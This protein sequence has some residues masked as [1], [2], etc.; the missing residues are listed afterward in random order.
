M[1]GLWRYAYGRAADASGGWAGVGLAECQETMS[2]GTRTCIVGAVDTLVSA[3]VELADEKRQNPACL[4]ETFTKSGG[5]DR[6]S[7]LGQ[8]LVQGAVRTLLVFDPVGESGQSHSPCHP[9]TADTRS[10]SIASAGGGVVLEMTLAKMQSGTPFGPEEVTVAGGEAL[11][12][13]AWWWSEADQSTFYA[14]L[15]THAKVR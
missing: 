2:L 12:T 5:V 8:E 14:S 11:L 3:I 6:L 9:W 1:L 4:G 15:L 10:P 7:E 13:A